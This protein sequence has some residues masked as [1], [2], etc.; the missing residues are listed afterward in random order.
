MS[1]AQAKFKA[2]RAEVKAAYDDL[3]S[4]VEAERQKLNDD[5]QARED[6]YLAERKSSKLDLENLQAAL[7]AHTST[8][9]RL[10]ASAPDISLLGMLGK[11]KARLEALESQTLPDD[12]KSTPGSLLLKS[13]A[14]DMAKKA[15]AAVGVLTDSKKVLL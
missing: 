6:T 13:T 15:V 10:V 4:S 2:M 11:L 14:V 9:E 5:I 1:D 3:Q 7:S 8:A 12:P